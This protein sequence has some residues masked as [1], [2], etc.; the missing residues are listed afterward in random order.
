MAD[1]TEKPKGRGRPKVEE[2]RAAVS[3]WLPANEH[4][5]L[6]QLANKHETSV[7]AL[8]RHLLKLRLP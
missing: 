1:E 3:T 8:V 6:I 2:P 5:R 4:D 7:S